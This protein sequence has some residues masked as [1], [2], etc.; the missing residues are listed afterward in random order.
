MIF[1]PELG[2][3]PSYSVIPLRFRQDRK[4]FNDGIDENLNVSRQKVST[5]FTEQLVFHSIA[6]T[7]LRRTPLGN[8]VKMHGTDYYGK[9]ILKS[10]R[11]K[12]GLDD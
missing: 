11:P 9:Q 10:T 6:F 12:R 1:P 5:L 2:Y 8:I 7:R 4:S 3:D